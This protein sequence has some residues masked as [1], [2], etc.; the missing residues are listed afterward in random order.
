[1]TEE[2][3]P[4]S[5]DFYEEEDEKPVPD[6]DVIE[7]L[8]DTLTHDM[9]AKVY[10]MRHGEDIGEDDYEWFMEELINEHYEMG[11]DEWDE[12]YLYYD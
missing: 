4:E 8:R 7:K 9:A 2:D 11:F 1:M 3:P 12:D 6:S 10:R 5:Y